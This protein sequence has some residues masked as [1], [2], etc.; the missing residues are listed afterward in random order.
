MKYKAFITFRHL[1]HWTKT[2]IIEAKSEKKAEDIVR[3][4]YKDDILKIEIRKESY[5]NRR[6][7]QQ[8]T[9]DGC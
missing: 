9:Q 6:D 4:M 1:P 7:T 3:H 8:Q 2:Q 5:D